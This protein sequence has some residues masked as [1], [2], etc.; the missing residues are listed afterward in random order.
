MLRT[1]ILESSADFRHI[2]AENHI[3]NQDQ[4][5]HQTADERITDSRHSGT[6]EKTF[7]TGRNSNKE[8]DRQYNGQNNGKSHYDFIYALAK[9]AGK[10]FF[11]F[12][13]FLIQHAEHF[14]GIFQGVHAVIQHGAHI[15]DAANEGFAHP[16]VFFLQRNERG[17]LGY[18]GAVR[19][20][21]GHSGG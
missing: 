15:N 8:Y 7:H 13:R 19:T 11:K 17:Q 20:A 2:T 6:A 9:L 16:G 3:A 18:H 10:P 14:C 12:G 21:D 1:V 4:D 5:F